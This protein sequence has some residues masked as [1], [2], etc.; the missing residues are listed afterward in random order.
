MKASG[1]I[2]TNA[3]H[4]EI[5]ID[6]RKEIPVSISGAPAGMNRDLSQWWRYHRDRPRAIKQLWHTTKWAVRVDHMI[7]AKYPDEV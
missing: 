2:D 3:L 7:E 1:R 6:E 4:V 5:V